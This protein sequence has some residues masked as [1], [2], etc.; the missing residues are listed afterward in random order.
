MSKTVRF[1]P[2]GKFEGVRNLSKLIG[3]LQHFPFFIKQ[4]ARSA[5]MYTV[6]WGWPGGSAGKAEASTTRRPLVPYTLKCESSTPPWSLVLIAQVQA[7]C[8]TNID[9]S[10]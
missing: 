3:A 5:I 9:T 4:A 8:H 1:M 10:S 6:D 7:A 2:L